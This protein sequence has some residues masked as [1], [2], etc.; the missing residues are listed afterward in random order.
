[1]L[2]ALRGAIRDIQ[3]KNVMVEIMFYQL[4]NLKILA[5][6]VFALSPLSNKKLSVKKEII[7]E[8]PDATPD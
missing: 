7:F 2:N 4:T 6:I 1:M 8:N 5:L 3:T